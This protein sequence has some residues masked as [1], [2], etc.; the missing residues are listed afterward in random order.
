[1]ITTATDFLFHT[2]TGLFLL[3]MAIV[4]TLGA[5]FGPKYGED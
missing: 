3:G 4:F 5:L 1:M 2:P